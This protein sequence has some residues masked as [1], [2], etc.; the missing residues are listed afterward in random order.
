MVFIEKCQLPVLKLTEEQEEISFDAIGQCLEQRFSDIVYIEYQG[1]LYGM[2][3]L[4]DLMRAERV[5]GQSVRINRN[6]TS[7][8]REEYIRARELFR[9]HPS[10]HD[11][12]VLDENHAVIGAFSRFDDLLFLKYW[13][14][15]E[16]SRF[17]GYFLRSFPV[18]ALV[19][20]VNGTEAEW[21]QFERFYAKLTEK[22]WS[23]DRIRWDQIPVSY[24]DHDKIVFVDEEQRRGAKAIMLIRGMNYSS[25]FTMTYCELVRAVSEPPADILL[26]ELENRGVRILMLYVRIP[27]N[28]YQRGIDAAF[29]RRS[30]T[31]RGA[32]ARVCPEE[33]RDF[34][35]ELY[36][37]EYARLVGNH[38]FTI[39]KQ[40]SFTF[41]QDCDEEYFHISGGVR[42]T[43]GV[44][45]SARSS[46]YF[47]GPCIT[48]GAFVEDRHTIESQLQEMLNEGGYPAKVVNC[49][50][51][52]SQYSE[53][54]RITSTPMK[55]GDVAVIFYNAKTF[56]GLEGVNLAEVLE[57][58]RVPSKW[59]LDDRAHCNHK[60]NRLYAE[61]I[62]RKLTDGMLTTEKGTEEEG[63]APDSIRG[64]LAISSKAVHYLF[65]D[66]YFWNL[67]PAPGPRIGHIGM[68]A[69]P[70]TNGHRYL[71]DYARERTD[72][73]IVLLI[74]D[75]LGIFSF[76]ER[77]AMAR[78]ATK[79]CPD[80]IVEGGGPFQA[81]RAVFPE[82][83]VKTENNDM[84]DQSSENDCTI[85]ATM[86][87][88]ALGINVRFFGDEQHNPQMERFNK[89]AAA[90]LPEHGIS[91]GE[92]PRARYQG[93]PISAAII[94][95]LA[96]EKNEEE[97]KAY[98]P[99]ST[100]TIMKGVSL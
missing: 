83:F 62:Y 55:K 72:R 27:D 21:E 96:A 47:F 35:E 13:D 15:W 36:T 38:S 85:F 66:R 25:D 60:V 53:L 19:E 40:N 65:L 67:P 82:Y 8:T 93:K 75:E 49:G 37:E 86:I 100:I 99:A 20:P 61:A 9:N 32:S 68:H 17:T 52:E 39:E 80:V 28:D 84:M 24:A 76:A 12:P 3:T 23:C 26:K 89:A 41:L 94:R 10:I 50:C 46:I 78:E 11:I 81:T 45:E 2:V 30:S 33:G 56:D 54:I 63:C 70:F 51:W 43:T 79:D 34:Y 77:F 91:V 92:I 5:G 22:G 14:G 42:R 57:E 58:N 6:F 4:G 48:V 64:H 97:L 71:I 95:Q 88:P 18:L 90:I 31:I 98:V 7:V 73:L 59:L 87:A 44:P 74:E 69:N 29:A 1:L 16:H